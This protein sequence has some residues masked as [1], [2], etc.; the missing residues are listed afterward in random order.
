MSKGTKLGLM[1]VS[2]IILTL[3]AWQINKKIKQ[4]IP[5]YWWIE[6]LKKEEITV[7]EK[8]QPLSRFSI[9]DVWEY[10]INDNLTRLTVLIEGYK[11]FFLYEIVWDKEMVGEINEVNGNDYGKAITECAFKEISDYEARKWKNDSTL[12]I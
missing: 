5:A 1:F 6:L 2:G 3:G 12:G 9:L 10:E 7:N 11:R 8:I 4:R